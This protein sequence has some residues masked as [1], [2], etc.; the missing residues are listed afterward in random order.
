MTS[1]NESSGNI[2]SPQPEKV[3]RHHNGESS[4]VPPD[5]VCC[6]AASPQPE[7]G[8]RH[9]NGESS[10]VPP[11]AVCCGAS[12]LFQEG[13]AE[14]VQ[15]ELVA[16][17]AS[18]PRVWTA[19]MVGILA[20]PLAAVVG[21]IV[22]A[23]AMLAF[24][25]T[26]FPDSSSLMD[27]WLEDLA[28]TRVGLVVIIV[29][30]QLVFLAAA[31]GA[32]WLSPQSLTQRLELGPGRLPWW[33]W[34]V[35]M[36]GT[37]IIGV[38]SSHVLSLLVDD[39]GDQLKLV[40][41]MLRTH[42]RDFAWGLLA[43]VAV[44]PG[45]VEELLFRGYLQSRLLRCWPPALAVGFSAVVFSLAHLDPVHVLGVLPLGLWLGAIAWRAGSIWPAILCHAINNAVAVSGA[46]FEDTGTWELTLD[47]Y[48]ITL[49][50]VSGPAFLVSLA[51]LAW[52]GGRGRGFEI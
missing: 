31:L 44:L 2:P 49:L 41:A 25:G 35:L 29:P 39:M 9:H 33:T 27:T 10:G 32:A 4:G 20:I 3:D 48:S 14:V 34:I 24:H 50:A 15:A 21:G 1:D 37:P 30:G 52:A 8:D 5:A 38:L 22:L 36:L 17:L 28:Q 47:P 26:P 23:A 51:I 18:G 6:G 7:K 42:V 13:P 46:L 45:F 16:P 11:D 19:L 12:P 43:L 40:D